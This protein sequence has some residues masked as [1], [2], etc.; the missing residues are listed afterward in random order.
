MV[1]CA[2]GM[3]SHLT[4]RHWTPRAGFSSRSRPRLE[5]RYATQLRSG[6]RERNPQVDSR[7]QCLPYAGWVRAGSAALAGVVVKLR[8]KT[9]ARCKQEWRKGLT[10]PA[11]APTPTPPSY[12]APASSCSTRVFRVEPLSGA[13]HQSGRAELFVVNGGCAA[14]AAVAVAR[15]GGRAALAGPPAAPPARSKR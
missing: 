6:S 13:R 2:Q 8:Q 12:C 7:F 4:A 9:L 3:A 5:T 1:T 14:N 10:P 15:L 11:R